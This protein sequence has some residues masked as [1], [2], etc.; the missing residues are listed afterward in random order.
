MKEEKK[1]SKITSTING[2]DHP[3]AGRTI[4]EDAISNWNHHPLLKLLNGLRLWA[5]KS[6][7]Y[8]MDEYILSVHKH[9]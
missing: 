4:K 3:S 1:T 7:S 8:I 5:S 9:K 6:F 2:M